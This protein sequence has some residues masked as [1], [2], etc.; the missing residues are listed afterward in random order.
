MAV[1]F[2][3]RYTDAIRVQIDWVK[4]W[5]WTTATTRRKEWKHTM[6]ALC[7]EVADLKVFSTA[8]ELGYVLNYN[9]VQSRATQRKRH[10]IA[11]THIVRSRKLHLE[12][13]TRAK[14]AKYSLRRALWGT[15]TYV[16]GQHWLTDLRS[17]IAKTLIPGKSTSN[18]FLACFFSSSHIT[19]PAVFLIWDNLRQVRQYLFSLTLEERMQFCYLASRH[20]CKHSEVWGPAGAFAYNLHRVG[21]HC[22][23]EGQLLTHTQ[24]T[25][26]LLS[27]D[28]KAVQACLDRAWIQHMFDT[29]LTR[30]EWHRLPIPTRRD[31]LALLE[32][33][34]PE[35]QQQVLQFI[36]GASML[37]KQ[38]GKFLDRDECCALCNQADSRSHRLLECPATQHVRMEHQRAVQALQDSNDVLVNMPLVVAPHHLDFA[39]WYFQHVTPAAFDQPLMQRIVT[40]VTQGNTVYFY[41]DGSCAR[42]HSPLHRRA[43]F[44][45]V[46]CFGEHSA[47]STDT[48]QF[49]M[50]TLAVAECPGRQTI[51]RAELSALLQLAV[52]L[53]P[54]HLPPTHLHVHTDSAYAE[55]VHQ[56]V[57]PPLQPATYFAKLNN[58]DLLSQFCTQP[59]VYQVY[60]VKAHQDPSPAESPE[61][62][63]HRQGNAAA[64]LAAKRALAHF[65]H[66]MPLHTDADMHQDHRDDIQHIYAY[67]CA[68]QTARAKLFQANDAP[69]PVGHREHSWT[70]QIQSLMDWTPFDPRN[71]AMFADLDRS[72]LQ[73]FLWGT[74]YGHQL[75]DWMTQVHWPTAP[76]PC[77]AGITWFELCWSFQ[78]YTQEGVMV[79]DGGRRNDFHPKRLDVLD[80]DT[81]YA[82]QVLAFERALTSLQKLLQIQHMPLNRHQATSLRIFGASHSKGGFKLRCAFPGQE[83]L[84]PALIQTCQL[85]PPPKTLSHPPSVPTRE[86]GDGWQADEHD[87]TDMERG[88]SHRVSRHRKFM[89]ETLGRKYTGG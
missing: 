29:Q 21:W 11:L 82:E 44:A 17:A 88:W 31:T 14:I 41:T 36:T 45:I 85:L 40:H 26:D 64:D 83:H 2:T 48:L 39:L 52:A 65:Q 10:Q 6:R 3:I 59:H 28:M 18:P 71:A 9:K 15:H 89:S 43:A 60:K 69:A 19:D 75:V 27:M 76:D 42:P 34:P 84:C 47:S 1:K 8:Q 72:P 58:H 7:P 57:T 81:P 12:V 87:R 5:T 24:E 23:R 32:K 55:G 53:A 38:L 37:A 51:S 74:R 50:H 68:L 67:L 33:Q 61:Q 79:N 62:I 16:V 54:L 49:H 35:A 66:T 30:P 86:L 73:Y 77:N 56:Q 63:M 25:F 22:T 70:K 4:T 13:S 20:S 78:W 46:V 80:P